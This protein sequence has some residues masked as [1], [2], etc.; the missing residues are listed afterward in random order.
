VHDST[1]GTF[2]GEVLHKPGQL[3]INGNEVKV[4]DKYALVLLIE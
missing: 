3:T 2:K 1:H 4:Y